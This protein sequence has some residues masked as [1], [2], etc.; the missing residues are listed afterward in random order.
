MSQLPDN[1]NNNYAPVKGLSTNIL[2][3]RFNPMTSTQKLTTMPISTHMDL[4]NINI[5]MD[6][7][8]LHNDNNNLLQQQ[9]L[10]NLTSN[11]ISNAT[12]TTPTTTNIDAMQQQL[13]A[14]MVANTNP[15]FQQMLLEQLKQQQSFSNNNYLVSDPLYQSYFQNAALNAAQLNTFAFNNVNTLQA[16]GG[17]T[18]LQQYDQIQ[19][20]TK[21]PQRRFYPFALFIFHLPPDIDNNGLLQ[22]FLPYGAVACHV[23]RH[24]DGGSR[25]FGFAYFNTQQ[26]ANIACEMMNGYQ[27]GYKRLKVSIKKGED[28]MIPVNALHTSQLNANALA[29]FNSLN[30]INPINNVLNNANNANKNL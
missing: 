4:N 2:Q 7:N 11:L 17:L 19:A 10:N 16:S 13:G 25:G 22:L 26:E 1:N 23:M 21:Q 12:S 20:V 6:P 27:I 3:Q 8:N 14:A 9:Q 15:L 18:T 24:E 28:H 30:L 5:K 29:N